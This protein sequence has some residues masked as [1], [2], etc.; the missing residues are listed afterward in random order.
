MTLVTTSRKPA[1]ELRTLGKNLAFAMGG[2]YSPR[3]KAGVDEVF[4]WG[5]PVLIISRRGR[6]P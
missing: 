5:D 6:K 1:P 2:K 3:G 4:S